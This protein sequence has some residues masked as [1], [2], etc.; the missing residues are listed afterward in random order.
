MSYLTPAKISLLAVIDVYVSGVVPDEAAVPLLSFVGSHIHSSLSATPLPGASSVDRWEKAAAATA[1]LT[2]I[3]EFEHILSPL[4]F[5]PFLKKLWQIDSLD[6]LHRFLT[7]DPRLLLAPTREELRLA[8]ENGEEL[9]SDDA[10]RLAPNSPFGNFVR[11]AQLE[12]SRLSFQKATEL[13][14]G[15]VKYRQPTAAA[16]W[17]RRNSGIGGLAFDSVLLAGQHEWGPAVHD[18]AQV[19]YGGLGRHLQGGPPGLGR[20]L[21]GGPPDASTEDIEFLLEF[22]VNQIQ[23]RHSRPKAQTLHPRASMLT[24]PIS[25]AIAYG[26]RIPPAV[27]RHYRE[28][29]AGSAMIPSLSHYVSFLEAWRSGDYP[30]SFDY[31]HRYFDYTMQNRDRLFYQ[32]ALLNLAI[33]QA[34]FGSHKEAVLTMLET[35]STARENR[36][37]ACLN[38]SLNWLFQFGRARPQLVRDLESG[39]ML[40][41]GK[42]TLSFLR[43]KA[44]EVNCWPLWSSALL[45]EAKLSLCNGESIATAVKFIMASSR[46]VVEHNLWGA[47]GAQLSLTTALWD[48]LGLAFLSRTMC[49]VFLRVHAR[50]AMFEDELK[51]TCCLAGLLVA[52][53]HYDEAIARLDALDRD[54]LRSWKVGR[55]WSR[56]RGLIRLRRELHRGDLDAADHF[57]SQLVQ[58]SKPDENEPDMTFIVD[59]LHVEA[60]TRRGELAA[61]LEMTNVRLGEQRDQGRDVCLRVRLLLARAGLHDRAGRSRKGF[62]L[63]LRAASA[64]WRARLLPALWLSL[65]SLANILVSLGEFS[66]AAR[67]LGEII[68][69]ALECDAA[70]MAGTLYLTLGDAFTGLAGELSEGALLLTAHMCPSVHPGQESSTA[71]GRPDTRVGAESVTLLPTLS[72][73]TLAGSK[74]SRTKEQQML[75]LSASAAEAFER[76]YSCFEAIEDT[77]KQCET[78]AKQATI[79]R[80]VGDQGRAEDYA[81]KYL[82]LRATGR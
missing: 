82:V 21:Q 73:T 29:L 41:V 67:L 49:E 5:L 65:G 52:R 81:S 48:R 18:V 16:Y 31:L 10:V 39:S 9:P 51:V 54:P 55:H 62:V 59:S 11:R 64:A 66:E 56:F 34:D 60:L 44:K 23:S 24:A 12:F 63:A 72:T 32:Y 45:S 57:I 8:A 22:Q 14:A 50:G 38:F 13:W 37:D 15:F 75:E 69:R 46:I 80:M 3:Q 74:Q 53:G 47:M 25:F 33:L 17:T 26:C 6:A 7:D 79:M 4:S 78:R 70:F 1:V 19:V 36:D 27:E 20:H 2:S 28:L 61:A 40:G 58:S 35:V 43:V 42:E 68:P 76:A 77:V 30:T 71:G